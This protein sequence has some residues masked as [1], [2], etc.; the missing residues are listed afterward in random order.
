MNQGGAAYTSI[1][2]KVPAGGV[3]QIDQQGTFVACLKSSVESC[4]ISID[5]AT[6]GIFY[7]G[8]KIRTQ[9]GQPFNFIIIDNTAGTVPAALTIAVGFGDVLD[10]S[11]VDNTQKTAS[12][13]GLAFGET[14]AAALFTNC[15][16]WNPAGSGIVAK[17]TSIVISTSVAQQLLA[18]FTTVQMGIGKPFGQS[19]YGGQAVSKSQGFDEKSAAANSGNLLNTAPLQSPM[20]PASS[21]FPLQFSDPLILPANMGYAIYSSVA[22]STVTVEF[23]FLEVTG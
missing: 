16:L 9:A 15:Q 6:P 5:G 1:S 3:Q 23:D 8:L 2:L 11:F 10:S 18:G 21:A 22:N 20:I 19:K 7:Q 4:K 17:I 14:G 13:F 12:G